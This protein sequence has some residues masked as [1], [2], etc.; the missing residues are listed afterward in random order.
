LLLSSQLESPRPGFP[1][2]DLLFVVTT[3]QGRCPPRSLRVSAIESMRPSSDPSSIRTLPD[4]AERKPTLISEQSTAE[5]RIYETHDLPHAAKH[6]KQS[7]GARVSKRIWGVEMG[8]K[9]GSFTEAFVILLI[10][11]LRV[12]HDSW[13]RRA[14]KCAS[15]TYYTTC[16]TSTPCPTCVPPVPGLPEPEASRIYR[17]RGRPSL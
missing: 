6:P 8:W 9:S 4:G 15:T 14:A 7:L 5:P 2:P 11:D 12:S 3:R 1:S 13:L 17:R 10:H 16:C